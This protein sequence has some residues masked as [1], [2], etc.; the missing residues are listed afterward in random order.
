MLMPAGT[1][2]PAKARTSSEV[3]SGRKNL[4]FSNPVGQ[5]R[6]LSSSSALS[7]NTWYFSDWKEIEIVTSR[8]DFFQVIGNRLVIP[9][10][11]QKMTSFRGQAS[12]A[13]MTSLGG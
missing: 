4:S 1:P 12:S 5:G 6:Y 10:C 11:K 2:E 13:K 9:E 3:K 7:T 8:A